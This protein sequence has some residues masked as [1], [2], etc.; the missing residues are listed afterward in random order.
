M[1]PLAYSLQ[2][3][4]V[5]EEGSEPGEF[6][7]HASAPACALVTTLTSA[8]VAGRFESAERGTEALLESRLV[9]ARNGSFHAVS[10]IVFGNGH[11]LRLRTAAG[12]QLDRSPDPHL[13]QGA[14]VWTVEGGEGQFAGACG[15]VASNFFLSDSG[16]VTDSHLGLIFTKEDTHNGS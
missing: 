10:T 8:G 3:R 5:A 1:R 16:E 2:F 13:R 9:I 7:A 14:A 4:G 6:T 12:A 15:R 11:V